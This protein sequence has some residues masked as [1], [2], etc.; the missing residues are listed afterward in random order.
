MFRLVRG[1]AARFG[2]H[3]DPEWFRPYF[4]AWAE[5]VHNIVGSSDWHW[6]EFKRKLGAVRVLPGAV[7]ASAVAAMDDESLSVEIQHD[8]AIRPITM[9]R[10]DRLAR[11]F[12]WLGRYHGGGVFYLPYSKIQ[13]ALKLPAKMEAGRVANRIEEAGFLDRPS[14]GEPVRGGAATEWRWLGPE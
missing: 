2:K 14:R 4:N 5:D 3:N 9:L 8:R 1:F 13:E 11:L 12:R 6:Q 10:A 7:W